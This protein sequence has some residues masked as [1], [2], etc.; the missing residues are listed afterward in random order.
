[1]RYLL[2]PLAAIVSACAATTPMLDSR[3]GLDTRMALAQQITNPG[4]RRNPDPVAGMDGRSAHAAYQRYQKA[5]GETQQ[6][7][8][9]M[10]GD[11]K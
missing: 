3:F 4:A 2:I 1:M 6:A 9:L 7:P 8:S 5:A 10:K 11:A